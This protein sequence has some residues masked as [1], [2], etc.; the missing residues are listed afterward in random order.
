MSNEPTEEAAQHLDA[1]MDTGEAYSQFFGY[2]LSCLWCEY[3]AQGKT[4]RE[5]LAQMQRHYDNF[6]GIGDVVLR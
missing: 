5:A 1:V 3:R 4:K 2:T 6:D